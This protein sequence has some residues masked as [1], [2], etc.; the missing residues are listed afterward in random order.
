MEENNHLQGGSA[1]QEREYGNAQRPAPQPVTHNRPQPPLEEKVEDHPDERA[2]SGQS[3]E[4]DRT[5][6][7]GMHG[8][9]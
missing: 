5:D 7:G 6:T 3:G 1:P 2:K 4:G 9:K 8:L